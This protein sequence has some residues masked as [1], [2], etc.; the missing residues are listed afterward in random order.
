V[1]LARLCVEGLGL[2][3]GWEGR[4]IGVD[5]LNEMVEE[6]ICFAC[7]STFVLGSHSQYGF[8]RSH[9]IVS[10]SMCMQ[11]SDFDHENS[12]SSVSRRS[13]LQYTVSGLLV[14]YSALL[15]TDRARA[16]VFLDTERYGDKEMKVSAI[17]KVKQNLRNL[18]SERPELLPSVLAL[19][20]HDALGFCTSTLTGG[21]NGSLKYELDR[22]YNS[23]VV[24]SASEIDAIRERL[25]DVSL[26]DHYAF[27]GAVAMEVVN[28]PRIV[29]QLGRE[30]AMQAD[31]L[32]NPNVMDGLLS[33]ASAEQMK[34]VF[35]RSGLEGARSAVLYHGAYGVLKSLGD[36][37][38]EALAKQRAMEGDDDD[39]FNDA[40]VTY[41][42][43]A[44]K[45]R[46]AVLVDSNVATLTLAGT[47]FDNAYLKELLAL[48][49]AGK[50]DQLS[51]RDKTIL[52]DPS[53]RAEVVKYAANSKLF[54]NDF[55]NMYERMTLLGSKYV[56]TKLLEK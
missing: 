24:E 37:K 38:A 50:L 16:E 6:R 29:V 13:L 22:K 48:E 12:R 41:G 2:G 35:E 55:A 25:S 19:G 56:D 32:E 44:R 15:P 30:D 17:N 1:Q 31:P 45:K 49:K 9:S 53:M 39:L 3:V 47:K 51:V 43:V 40:D 28:G 20:V 42:R 23:A 21:P 33:S 54:A 5:V 36:K 4:V 10:A 34:S 8:Q 26:A 46:G 7:P 11:T 52:S 27:C 18:L 14:G